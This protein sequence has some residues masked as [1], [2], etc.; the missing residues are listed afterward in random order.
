MFSARL[1]THGLRTV[2]HHHQGWLL[3]NPSA[4]L[5]GTPSMCNTTAN[6]PS[7]PFDLIANPMVR[8]PRALRTKKHGID[9]LHDP[10]WNK[11]TAFSLE[12]RD[13]LGVRGLLPPVLKTIEQQKER[14]LSHLSMLANDVEKNRYLQDFQNRNET[15]F[16]RIL[17]DHLETVAPLVYTP[18][19]GVACE[20]FGYM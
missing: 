9:V 14:V 6:E 7:D 2:Q 5:S 12:E 8:H 3:R 10:M 13:R 16:H 20:K 17:A 19:V 1:F 4:L 15:L 18:T 11:G